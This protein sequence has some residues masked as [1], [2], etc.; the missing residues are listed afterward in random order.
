MQRGR[1]R[2]GTVAFLVLVGRAWAASLPLSLPIEAV[3]ELNPRAWGAA[4]K[5]GE[6]VYRA[7]LKG[8]DAWLR[9]PA[10]WGEGVRPPKGARYVVE[11]TYKDV[12]DAPVV[13]EAFNALGSYYSR[14]ELHRFGGE[15]DGKWKVAQVPVSW[16]LV[17]LPRD[18]KSAEL[19][20]RAPADVPI[21]HLSIRDAKLPEDQA[22]YE[23]ESRAWVAKVQAAKAA[24]A[25]QMVAD[26][27][28]DIP[29]THK[30]KAIVPYVRAYYDRIYPNSAPRQGEAAATIHVRMARNE[31]EPGTFAVYA[32]ED[33]PGVDFAVSE[34]TGPAGKLACEVRRHTAEFAL[35]PKGKTL[36]WTPQRLWPAFPAAIK[37]GRSAWFW[38]TL[39]TL[40]DDSKPGKYRGKVT[41]TAGPHAA[42]LPIQVEVLPVTLLT[43]D[44]AGLRMGGCV[45]GL[46]TAGEM[47]TMRE[48]NHNMVNLW[49]AGVQPEMRKEGD[50]IVLDFHYLDDW[51]QVA[52]ENG[53]GAIVWFLGGNPNGFPQTL[54][55]ERDLYALACGPRDDFFKKAGSQEFRGKILPEVREHYK[56]WL[57]DVVAHAKEKGWPEL[58][59]TP[60]DEPA[61]W[62][63][64]EPRADRS[65]PFA[66]GCGP[67]IRDHFKDAC[68]LIHEAVPGTKVYIS[69]HRNFHRKVHGTDGRVGEIFIPDCD[70]ICTNAIDEDNELGNKVRNAGKIFWQYS[71]TRSRRFGFGFYFAAW[72][73]RGSLCWAYNWGRRFDTTEGSNWEYAWYSP[74][75]TILTPDY[76]ELRE[77]WDDRR[78]VETAKAAA[79]A[80]GKD[81]SDLL[82]QIR[83]ETLANQGTGGRDL[84]NDFWEEGRQANKM[85]QWR[86]L[87]A[88]RIAELTRR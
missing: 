21:S 66:I 54:S 8:Q 39:R 63:Y 3:K 76:E 9:V 26:E 75:D 43:M 78:Y 58:I 83:T 6:R 81:I 80:A 53:Q 16:D 47:A 49:F 22:R 30:G 14:R 13:A 56:R 64:T 7:A 67:W 82:A 41:I 57:Q 77:A 40:G 23:A 70:V 79:K 35:E 84:V 68:A 2:L 29:E 59:L 52:K 36:V 42:E 85:D 11:V 31:F 51:M 87:L 38:I 5:E 65:Y 46:A 27:T 62:A 32:Q 20:F 24:G 1:A 50:R 71:G 34:L 12:A 45:T 37:R 4:A 86:E 25:G 18:T 28:P 10:W 17:V 33:L 19:A 72:D 15:N 55:I 69:M 44:E 88:R 60:F 48:H 61:K 74:F 73:S